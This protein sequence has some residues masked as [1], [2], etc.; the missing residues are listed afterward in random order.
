ME[1]SRQKYWGVLPFPSPGDLPNPGIESGLLHC[2][3][4]LYCLNYQGCLTHSLNE[5]LDRLLVRDVETDLDAL[6]EVIVE[7]KEVEILRQ[8]RVWILLIKTSEDSRVKN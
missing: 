3:Q 8:K 2:R 4:I 6:M 1:F 5:K 7:D